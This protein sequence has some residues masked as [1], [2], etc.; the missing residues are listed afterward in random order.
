MKIGART[1]KSGLSIFLA[2][3]IPALFNMPDGLPLAGISAVASLQ[4]SVKKSFQTLKDRIMAN[5][6][7]AIVAV[8]TVI[9]F[10]NSYFM[11][12][13]AS[14][15]LIA[16]LHQFKLNNVI[17]LSTIT[18]IVI[19]MSTDYPIVISASLRVLATIFGVV[20]SFVINGV[21]LPPKYDEKLFHLNNQVTDDL[22]RFIRASLRKNI[23]YPMMRKDLENLEKSI[24][25][26]KVYLGHLIDGDLRK[27]FRSSEYSYARLIVVYRQFI[28]TTDAAYNLVDTLHQAE[29]VYNHFPQELRHLLIERLETLMSAHEQIILKWNGRVLPEEVNFITHK[30][31]LRKSFMDSFFNE[32]NLE[33]YL[34]NEYSQ[35]NAVIHIMSSVLD[36]EES[37]QHLNRLV[38]SFKKNHNE[39]SSEIKELH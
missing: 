6:I 36:Y 31:S 25:K 9:L 13:I 4:P 14:A 17:V 3:S 16:I 20:S 5:T 38:S 10:G 32:A 27:F 2:L 34:Q 15:V 11:I 39:K 22:T 19:M 21:L 8:V 12:S 24:T 28:H 7:G 35:S 33:S 1:F 23:Q 30:S 18:L 37:L 29:N 26:M